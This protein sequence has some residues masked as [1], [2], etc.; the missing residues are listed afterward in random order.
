MLKL[1]T[2][3]FA[4][5][6]LGLPLHAQSSQPQL[7]LDIAPGIQGSD[8]QE[9][10]ALGKKT[11]FVADDL[12]HGRE[13]WITDGT[14]AGTKM[15]IDLVPGATGSHPRNL[16]RMGTQVAFVAE[17]PSYGREVWLTDGTA[18]GTH[19]LANI[20]AGSR[21]AK[22]EELVVAQGLLF[23]HVDDQ[24]HGRELWVSDGT[25]AGTKM[26]KDIYPGY[27]GSGPKFLTPWGKRLAFSAEDPVH[28]RELWVSDGTAA[29]TYVVAD[30][31]HGIASGDPHE[32]TEF[33]DKL[34]FRAFKNGVGIELLITDGTSAGTICAHDTIPGNKS[35]GPRYLLA[36]E[37]KL[38]YVGALNTAAFV[39][40]GST[41]TRLLT[42]SFPYTDEGS[43]FPV[44]NKVMFTAGN[45][46]DL[47]VTDGSAG[48]TKLVIPISSS[49]P[50]PRRPR[51]LAHFGYGRVMMGATEVSH[52]NEL[53][54]SDGTEQGTYPMDI[55]ARSGSSWPAVHRDAQ[56]FG[57]VIVV[58]ND[59]GVTGM[60]PR[61]FDSGAVA[62]QHGEG[63]AESGCTPSFWSTDPK[64]GG[65]VKWGGHCDQAA[66]FS[67]LG[68]GMPGLVSFTPRASIYLDLLQSP[69]FV[70]M[71][72]L[73]GEWNASMMIPNSPGL[74][75]LQLAMQSFV[76]NAQ[77]SLGLDFS[78]AMFWTLR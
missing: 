37:G 31:K 32:L 38:Y 66:A 9:F 41:S 20:A 76:P 15:L 33:G 7:L 28:G 65:S 77:S 51:F 22:P 44:G 27:S 48:G 74:V 4:A 55:V 18:S 69:V 35:G 6:T 8:P 19:L 61:I 70:A 1:R 59:Y 14:S 29:G 57:K 23:F 2:S 58:A 47:W 72:V 42:S 62:Q 46:Q 11:L 10:T 34:A 25:S 78:P 60:E 43:F 50:R 67:I 30:L 53:W 36:H 39:W 68:I 73:Q 21:T 16:V 64:L 49:A 52:G 63:F 56:C 54:I 13:L 12:V 5:M 71:P 75:G 26:V 45:N 17:E 24:I 3:L 40:D